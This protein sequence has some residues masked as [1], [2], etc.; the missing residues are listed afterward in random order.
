MP[1]RL[2]QQGWFRVVML[3]IALEIIA[4]S[5]NFF[6]APINVAAG[7]ATGVAILLDAAFGINRA[8]TV[9]IIN[10]AMIILAAIFL[11]KSTVRNIAFGSFLL[12]VLMYITPSHRLVEDAVLAVIIGGAVFASGIAILYR[13]EASSGGTTVPPMI[14]KKYFKINSALSLLAIDMVVTLFNLLVSGT[15]AF[16]LAAFSLVITSIVM[17]YIET[18]LDLKHQVTIMSNERL[19]DIQT[20]LLQED[21]SLT[22]FDVR[23]G[24][25]DNNKEMLMVMVDNGNYGRMLR[26]VHDID[27]NAFIV[28]TNV[29]EVHGGTFG[30]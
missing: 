27:Q 6:Y 29:H 3:V 22:V 9:L 28:T 7:G 20:M 30:I 24:Y 25:T 12:P 1:R 11:D 13:L 8:L 4:L 2:S 21:Q 14:L 26:R 19:A 15:N 16:F 23:G 18:G 10:I 17:R 5:I